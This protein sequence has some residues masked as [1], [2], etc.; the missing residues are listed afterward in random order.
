MGM[1]PVE[2]IDRI[3]Y[4]QFLHDGSEIK[5][6]QAPKSHSQTGDT[7]QIGGLILPMLKPNLDVPVVELWLK[8]K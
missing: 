6:R 3:E 2:W 1:L 7:H 8:G 5:I 4:A